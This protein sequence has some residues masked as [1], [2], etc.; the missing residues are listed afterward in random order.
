MK[1]PVKTRKDTCIPGIEGNI[2]LVG[3]DGRVDRTGGG[4]PGDESSMMQDGSGIVN[5]GS[6]RIGREGEGRK[7]PGVESEKSGD[8]KK[9]DGDG[10]RKTGGGS[11]KMLHKVTELITLIKKLM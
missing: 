11:R 10:R 7:K 5:I 6:D 4:K 3:A 1:S 8:W 2:I 9:G